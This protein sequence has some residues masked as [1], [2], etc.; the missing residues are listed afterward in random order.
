MKEL[1]NTEI[2]LKLDNFFKFTNRTERNAYLAEMYNSLIEHKIEILKYTDKVKKCLEI[3]KDTKIYNQ[4]VCMF[5]IK[6]ELENKYKLKQYAIFIMHQL[7]VL[8]QKV[9]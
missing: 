2:G 9:T 5:V 1:E 7:K 3:I 6:K 8:Y 4:L